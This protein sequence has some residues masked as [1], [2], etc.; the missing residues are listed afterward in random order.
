VCVRACCERLRC[1]VSFS[2]KSVAGEAYMHLHALVGLS[3][4]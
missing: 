3:L 1:T 2:K 4:N